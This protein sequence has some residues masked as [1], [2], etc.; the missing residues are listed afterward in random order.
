MTYFRYCDKT[1]LCDNIGEWSNIKDEIYLM[2]DEALRGNMNKEMFTKNNQF[3]ILFYL[4]IIASPLRLYA[5]IFGMDI[6][7]DGP[8]KAIIAYMKQ[9]FKP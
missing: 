9:A 3:I 5:F 4:F 6:P 2:L 8:V 1:Y 7:G